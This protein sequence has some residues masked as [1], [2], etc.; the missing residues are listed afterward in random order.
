LEVEDGSSWREEK[1]KMMFS[2]LTKS[3]LRLKSKIKS[4]IF[5]R[6]GKSDRIKKLCKI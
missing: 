6:H 5:H 3:V 2:I 1:G 4:Y